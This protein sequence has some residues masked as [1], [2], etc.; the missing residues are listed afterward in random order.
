MFRPGE[1]AWLRPGWC[2]AEVPAGREFRVG[3]K[4]VRSPMSKVT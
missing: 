3:E 2:A 4:K 1:F